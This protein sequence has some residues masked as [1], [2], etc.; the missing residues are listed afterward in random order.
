MIRW[1]ERVAKSFLEKRGFY[2]GREKPQADQGEMER[3][4]LR[5]QERLATVIES[6]GR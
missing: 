2:V 5:F 3:R 4:R 1:L 6:V